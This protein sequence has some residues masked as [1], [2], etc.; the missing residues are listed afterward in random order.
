M[1]CESFRGCARVARRAGKG[2]AAA[3]LKILASLAQDGLQIPVEKV[4]DLASVRQAYQETS[5]GMVKGKA[6]VVFN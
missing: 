6:V 4:Y 3:G 5:R 1:E 2:T